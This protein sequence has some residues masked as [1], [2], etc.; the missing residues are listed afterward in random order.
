MY[1]H[2]YVTLSRL[3]EDYW[4]YV[5]LKRLVLSMVRKYAPLNAASKVLDIG[6]G[7][8]GTLSFF[9]EQEPGPRF[10]GVDLSPLAI[11]LARERC[12]ST[13]VRG[14][15]NELPFP[16]AFFDL[17]ISLDVFY[18]QGVD[19]EKALQEAFRVLKPGGSFILNLPAWECL[20]GEHDLAVHTRHRYRVPELREKLKQAGF[21]IRRLTYW[22][23][24]LF[25]LIFAARRVLRAAKPHFKIPTSD[26]KPL[27]PFLNEGLKSVL[28][29]ERWMVLNFNLPLGSSVLAVVERPTEK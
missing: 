17:A 14:S 25:P 15:V 16:A 19:D 23:A 4:W 8:G 24:F 26:L 21:Q 6:C 9:E 10:Y 20:R 22:N 27:P 28:E 5:G 3:E 29:L 18:I 13:L 12:R 7:T 11:D 2:E 1:P